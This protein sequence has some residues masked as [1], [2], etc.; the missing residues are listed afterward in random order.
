M[1]NNK[2][3]G[4]SELLNPE[5][6]LKDILEI[7]YNS[8]V[9]SLGCGAMAFFTLAAAKLIGNKGQVYACDILKDVL[10][11]VESKARQA[12]FYNIKTVWTNLEIVGA[13]NIS[14]ESLDYA[15]LVNVLFQTQKHLEVLQ[16][17]HRLIKSNGKLLIIDWRPA[18]G[19]I[20]PAREMRLEQA[21]IERMANEVG[22]KPAKTFEAGQY[23]YGLIFTK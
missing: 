11:S 17:A 18:G 15:F 3:K 7:A 22:F 14:S 16:E 6:I 12:G 19:P 20:G 8:R 23:H 9:A 13:T 4:G 21:D 2:Y 1:D 5:R 10:S